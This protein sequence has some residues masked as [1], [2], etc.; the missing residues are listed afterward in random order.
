M[1]VS[2]VFQLGSLQ[3]LIHPRK[4]DVMTPGSLP[5]VPRVSLPPRTNWPLRGRQGAEQTHRDTVAV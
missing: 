4:T 3:G 5:A 1:K 2:L